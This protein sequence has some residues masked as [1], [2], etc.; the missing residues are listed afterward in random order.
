ME[1]CTNIDRNITGANTLLDGLSNPILDTQLHNH[2]DII[3]ATGAIAIACTIHLTN[4]ITK[5]PVR[6][7][8]TIHNALEHLRPIDAVVSI[9][10]M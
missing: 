4:R 3:A 1:R 8:P 5:W 10:T 9:S 2:C 7:I 6:Y